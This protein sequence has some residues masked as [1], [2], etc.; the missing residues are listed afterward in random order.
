MPLANLKKKK[1]EPQGLDLEDEEYIRRA[2]A[3]WLRGGSGRPMPANTS[4]VE[5]YNGKFYVELHNFNGTLAVYRIRND[6]VLKRLKR[7]PKEV[8]PAEGEWR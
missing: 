8:A 6:G 7:W 1:H 3:A 5:E 4:S 2:I